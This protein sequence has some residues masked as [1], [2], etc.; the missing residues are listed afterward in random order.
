MITFPQGAVI[1]VNLKHMGFRYLAQVQEYVEAQHL[2]VD[3]NKKKEIIMMVFNECCSQIVSNFKA[4]IGESLIGIYNVPVF[5]LIT[6]TTDVV[7]QSACLKFKNETRVFAM[8]VYNELLNIPSADQS[9][10]Y[11]LEIATVANLV[12]K[13]YIENPLQGEVYD[14][15]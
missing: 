4:T 10:F 15:G 14:I 8:F 11:T 5:S 2:N 6:Y 7:E 12:L 9:I 13:R 3:E 1:N